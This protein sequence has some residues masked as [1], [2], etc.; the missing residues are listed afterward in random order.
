M[1][2]LASRTGYTVEKIARS[3]CAPRPEAEAGLE[4]E[5]IERL[6]RSAAAIQTAPHPDPA[7]EDDYER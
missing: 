4:A 7:K 1:R 5:D 3:L 6:R 2:A